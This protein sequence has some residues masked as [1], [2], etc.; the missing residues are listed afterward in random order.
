[1]LSLLTGVDG[2]IG[3]NLFKF[4]KPQTKIIG[5]SRNDGMTSS[6]GIKFSIRNPSTFSDIYYC[7]LDNE[8]WVSDFFRNVK[9]DII[10]HMAAEQNSSPSCYLNNVSTFHFNFIHLLFF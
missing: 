4:I 1:M 9:P 2:F 8:S 3:K 10:Y 7:K 5:I 6:S